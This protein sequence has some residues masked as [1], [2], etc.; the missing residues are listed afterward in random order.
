MANPDPR[1][2]LNRVP[3]TAFAFLRA[4][5]RLAVGG[6]FLAAG[7]LAV[8]TL[9]ILAEIATASL[10]KVFPGFPADIPI[11]WEY[12]AYLMG[13]A[14]MLGSALALRAG[15]HIRVS[16]L[17]G[18]MGTRGQR[19][20]ETVSS[21]L[22]TAMAAYLAWILSAFAARSIASFQVS[23]A[24]HTPLW[25]V[26]VMLAA[27]AVVLLFAMVARLVACLCGLPPDNTDLKAA[28]ASE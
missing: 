26:Q 23:V 17:L 3:G 19:V 15:A 8:M 13:S 18:A 27:G 24:S 5:D 14:F 21:A 10:S 9:L 4:V 12:S 28:T 16:A 6:G 2:G 25:P 11:V 20:L 1:R 22:G 7:C